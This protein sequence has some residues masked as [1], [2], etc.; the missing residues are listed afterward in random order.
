M[1]AVAFSL[2]DAQGEDVQMVRLLNDS[3][4]RFSVVKNSRQLPLSA[5]P[6]CVNSHS[7][8]IETGFAV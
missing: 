8:Q 7:D 3:H 6:A 4:E 1:E 5:E 2:V